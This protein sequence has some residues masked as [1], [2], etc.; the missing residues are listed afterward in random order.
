[1]IVLLTMVLPTDAS[2]RHAGRRLKRGDRRRQIVIRIHQ[3]AGTGHDSVPVRIWIVAERDVEAILEADQRG[4][5][6]G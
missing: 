5:R 6:I 1:M 4:H 2:G 3:A